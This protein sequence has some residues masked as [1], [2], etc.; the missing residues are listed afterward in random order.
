MQ[1]L[2][3]FLLDQIYNKH[4]QS[5]LLLILKGFEL[6]QDSAHAGDARTAYDA[7]QFLLGFFDRFPV[8]AGRPFWIAG[9]SYGGLHHLIPVDPF[10]PTPKNCNASQ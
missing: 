2:N 4:C 1:R 8:Y 10:L 3:A 5:L 7:L 9:E 6:N